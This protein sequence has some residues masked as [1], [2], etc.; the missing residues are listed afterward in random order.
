MPLLSTVEAGRFQEAWVELADDRLNPLQKLRLGV[1]S[2]LCRELLR[3]EI[4]VHGN[5]GSRAGQVNYLL[6]ES[7]DH[8]GEI[9]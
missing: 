9:Q 6:L 3:A 1:I 7:G 2:L 5:M 4:V 8:G